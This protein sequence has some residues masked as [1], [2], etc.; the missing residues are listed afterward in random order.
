[1]R[2]KD[3]D[4]WTDPSA[5]GITPA[6]AG[7]SDAACIHGAVVGDHPR[8]WGEK[9]PAALYV[10]MERGITPAYAGKSFSS[11]SSFVLYWDHP[12]VCG[13]KV[14][15]LWLCVGSSGSPPRMRGKAGPADAG[16][17]Q[18]RDHPRVCGEKWGGI[19]KT[20]AKGGSP[21]RM[22]GK[23][24]LLFH[25]LTPTRITPAYAGKRPGNRCALQRTWDHPRVC[26][27]K[28][29]DGGIKAPDM[30]SPPRMRGKGHPN[31][32]GR[33]R[34]GITPAYAGKRGFCNYDCYYF[35]DHPRVC[36]EKSEV[37]KP[38]GCVQGSPPRMRGKGTMA[39]PHH[40]AGGITPAYAGKRLK[41][42]RSTVPPVA[43]VPLFPSVCNKPVVSDGSPAG[44]D[45]PLFLPAENAVPASPAYNLRSL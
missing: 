35:R 34:H 14:L 45:A 44:R 8:V 21:P 42:S 41:R 20:I 37:Q 36:G 24:H 12:R 15:P 9:W 32:K 3:L 27:E 25:F 40:R 17:K 19:L 43:I 1:M 38:A 7:K 16:R 29:S 18:L 11:S 22:R 13:E 39:A 10:E 5:P 31:Q 23:V 2:G 4:D 26:G 28:M 30:G 33:L 6:Y